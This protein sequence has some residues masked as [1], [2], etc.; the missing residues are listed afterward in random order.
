MKNVVLRLECDQSNSPER[1]YATYVAATSDSLPH[2]MWKKS[3]VPISSLRSGW[4]GQITPM[5]AS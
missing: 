3:N 4:I 2:K 1:Q 5:R